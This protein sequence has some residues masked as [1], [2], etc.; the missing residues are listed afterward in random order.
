[1]DGAIV[2][3]LL[4]GDADEETVRQQDNEARE[5]GVS[6]VPAFIFNDK[7]TLGGAQDVETFVRIMNKVI[8]KLEV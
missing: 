8:E 4:A 3:D 2:K 1:M 5:M 7:F 6:G